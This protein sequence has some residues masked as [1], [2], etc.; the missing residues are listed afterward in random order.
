MGDSSE[1]A[2][3]FPRPGGLSPFLSEAVW[4]VL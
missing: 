4:L 1:Q 2:V 3:T